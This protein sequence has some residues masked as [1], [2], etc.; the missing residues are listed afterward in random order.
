MGGE[1]PLIV[2]G[3]ELGVRSSDRWERQKDAAGWEE[4][5]TGL[6]GVARI[7]QA[8]QQGLEK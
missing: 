2:Q 5:A 3:T 8:T 4:P 1:G 7:S 6:G